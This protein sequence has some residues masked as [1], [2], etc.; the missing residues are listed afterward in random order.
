[1]VPR[2]NRLLSQRANLFISFSLSLSLRMRSGER[3]AVH[4]LDTV[5]VMMWIDPADRGAAW[6]G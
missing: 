3:D 5:V 4:R 1:M 2:S 6:E